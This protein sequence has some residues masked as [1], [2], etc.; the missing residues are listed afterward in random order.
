MTRARGSVIAVLAA[1]AA[2]AAAPAA[3]ACTVLS[4]SVGRV[5]VDVLGT[6]IV[7][8]PGTS[9]TVELEGLVGTIVCPLLGGGAPGAPVPQ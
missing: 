8:T 9:V 3:N 1:T 2:L 5:N 7:D 6:V 4:A